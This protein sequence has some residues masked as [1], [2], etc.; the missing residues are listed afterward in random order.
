GPK[1][2]K[3]KTKHL[4]TTRAAL[5][6]QAGGSAFDGNLGSEISGTQQSILFFSAFI[7]FIGADMKPKYLL[8]QDR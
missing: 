3:E 2:E 7:G 6:T 5:L 1:S 8:T 4:S